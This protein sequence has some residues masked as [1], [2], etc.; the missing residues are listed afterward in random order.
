MRSCSRSELWLTDWRTERQADWLTDWLTDGL[1]DW[2]AGW[3]LGDQTSRVRSQAAQRGPG[4]A[5]FVPFQR[6]RERECVCDRVCVCVCSCPLTDHLYLG[7]LLRACCAY[8]SLC[9]R[10]CVRP[11]KLRYHNRYNND[12]SDYKHSHPCPPAHVLPTMHQLNQ[13]PDKPSCLCQLK[14][15][16]LTY[17]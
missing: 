17:D 6:E 14:S 13:S 2:E 11:Q 7:K 5:A 10:V 9:T 4:E 3:L 12:H 8:P 16:M 1:T 15:F